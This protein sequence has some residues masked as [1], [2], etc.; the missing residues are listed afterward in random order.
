MLSAIFALGLVGRY[1]VRPTGPSR[2]AVRLLEGSD[3]ELNLSQRIGERAYGT[4]TGVAKS[5]SSPGGKSSQLPVELALARLHRDMSMLDQA[6]SAKT[7]ISPT[8]V[9]VLG[10]TVLVAGI[11]PFAFGEKLVE[12]LVPS[13][14][15]LS[16]AIGL[17]AEYNGKVEVARGKE[18]AAITLQAAAEAES[19]LAQASRNYFDLNELELPSYH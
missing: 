8:S 7:S 18:I 17:S 13:M 9:L 14:S 19:F 16:A 11:A 3:S 4:V 6:A 10:A 1:V 2:C 15:A 12:V 5:L